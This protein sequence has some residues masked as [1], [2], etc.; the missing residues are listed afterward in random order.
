MFKFAAL[1]WNHLGHTLLDGGKEDFPPKFIVD[2]LTVI[3]ITYWIF[4]EESVHRAERERKKRHCLILFGH[5][6]S[7]NRSEIK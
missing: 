7:D 6:E 4:Q 5:Y 3:A 2:I 1:T